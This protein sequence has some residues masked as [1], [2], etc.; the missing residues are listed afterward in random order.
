MPD[1]VMSE[2]REITF[3]LSKLTL[4]EYRELF[5]RQQ[6]QADEDATMRKVTGLTQEELENLPLEDYKRLFKAFMGR[7]REPIADPT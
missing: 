7:C 6:P 4:K 5:N 2:G 1:L 3:D